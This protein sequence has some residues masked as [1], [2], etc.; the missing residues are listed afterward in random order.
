M[1]KKK[2]KNEYPTDQLSKTVTR[3]LDEL[4]Q[5]KKTSLFI[6]NELSDKFNRNYKNVHLLTRAKKRGTLNL[7]IFIEWMLA[8]GKK[9]FTIKISD[10]EESIIREQL[11]K[12]RPKA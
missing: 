7:R 9:E 4:T 5:D 6:I 12:L 2:R 3:I 10:E 1:Y 8:A 11:L